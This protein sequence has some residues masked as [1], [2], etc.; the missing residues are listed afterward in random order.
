[1]EPMTLGS[2]VGSPM[3]SPSSASNNS[4]Y[5]P[6]FLLGEAT[7]P[8]RLGPNVAESTRFSNV[9]SSNLPSPI[10]SYSTPD[11]RHN[12]QKAIF[13]NV[14]SPG[15][16]RVGNES[17]V[18][19]PPTRGLFDTVDVTQPSEPYKNAEN[20]NLS[21]N[22]ARVNTNNVNDLFFMD[23]NTSI[24]NNE[25]THGLLRWI[26]VFGF[27][28]DAINTVLSHISNRVRI[29]DKHPAPHPQ[30][31]WIHLKCATEQEAQRALLCNGNI[32]SGSIMIGVTPCTDEG[33]ILNPD[34]ENRGNL[35]RSMRIFSSPT[36][37]NQSAD[38]SNIVRS[39]KIQNA[40]PLATG[41][42]HHLNSQSVRSPE[43]VPQKASGIVSKAMEL[44]F[45]W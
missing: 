16:P 44:V 28:P 9:V 14:T 39:P 22:Q 43:N 36:K 29:V 15:S 40:R 45:G 20:L 24:S 32:V 18:G 11:Y 25:P 27:P 26:T 23:N 35:N 13:A 19:G 12:R 41:Y 31:N 1:M 5:L 4:A 37:L 42:N 7:T 17:H 2:P 6:S 30:S 10:P 3:Q 8:A 33:V 21:R 38:Y 34:K